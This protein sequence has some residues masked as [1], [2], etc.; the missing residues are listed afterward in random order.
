M[1]K[2]NSSRLKSQLRALVAV[3]EHSNFREA[4]LHLE[5]FQSTVSHAITPL[6]EELEVR[7]CLSAVVTA[8]Y[9]WRVSISP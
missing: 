7:Y 5:L 8:L 4:A 3:V 6:E 1:N 2:I 9:W